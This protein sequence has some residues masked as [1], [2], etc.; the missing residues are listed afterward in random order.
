MDQDTYKKEL[1]AK[2]YGG[3]LTN[4]QFEVLMNMGKEGEEGSDVRAAYEH[5][6]KIDSKD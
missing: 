4:R 6:M 2:M 1:F 3:K 5:K